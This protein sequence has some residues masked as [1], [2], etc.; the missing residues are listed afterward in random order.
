MRVY[1]FLIATV[2]RPKS[3]VRV[4]VWANQKITI[5]VTIQCHTIL[6]LHD[7]VCV[8][9][10]LGP[11]QFCQQ[12]LPVKALYVHH[13]DFASKEALQHWFLSPMDSHVEQR[14][15]NWFFV[16]VNCSFLRLF[17]YCT[18]HCPTIFRP[19]VCCHSSTKCSDFR[20]LG[21]SVVNYRRCG[22][23]NSGR[24]VFW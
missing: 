21:H 14:W 6:C 4:G 15:W 16:T 10:F 3:E 5:H 17:P 18:A 20:T 9:W 12:P 23:K 24:S 1:F 2:H 8:S 13:G 11:F 22:S 7:L 19:S